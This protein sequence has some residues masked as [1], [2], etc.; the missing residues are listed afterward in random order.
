MTVIII[1]AILIALLAVSLLVPYLAVKSRDREIER[2]KKLYEER[3]LTLSE[4]KN[5]LTKLYKEEFA[6]LDG[7]SYFEDPWKMDKVSSM[8][9]NGMKIKK[10]KDKYPQ[11]EGQFNEDELH[12]QARYAYGR[13]VLYL[14]NE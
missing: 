9:Q 12:E 3:E 10:L 2:R 8:A 14:M 1:F 13:D 7:N 11:Y 4:F 6:I 5:E